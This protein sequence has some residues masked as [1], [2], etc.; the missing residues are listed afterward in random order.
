M[1][2]NFY[3]ILSPI[4]PAYNLYTIASCRYG[5]E[6]I[7][8]SLVIKNRKKNKENFVILPAYTCQVVEN[9]ILAAGCLPLY[10]DINEDDWSISIKGFSEL[11]QNSIKNNNEILAVL[12]QHTYG[13]TPN[14]RS[15]IIELSKIY[16]ISVIDD[17]AHCSHSKDYISNL[18]NY[19]SALIGSFQSSKSI[20]AFQGGLIA[21]RK[22]D[23]KLK[24]ITLSILSKE[25]QAFSLRL[26]LAQLI[27]FSL[28]INNKPFSSA[29]KIRSLISYV[30]KG[31][32]SYEKNFDLIKYKNDFFRRGKAN[33]FTNIFIHFALNNLNKINHKRLELS[34][35]YN[36]IFPIN[37]IIT[38]QISKGNPLLLWPIKD[39][40]HSNIIKLKLQS[41]LISDWYSPM[42]F[43]NSSI[44]KISDF[45]NYPV[46]KRLSIN[47]AS[48]Y[49]NISKEDQSYLIKTL[50]E[51]D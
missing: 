3:K 27:Y 37:S 43:P 30:Y 2:S 23:K 8:R 19:S 49:T 7:L 38:N 18:S 36:S 51:F 9:A 6:L 31:M 22:N 44:L 17:I 42:I 41:R 5:I 16:N 25:K 1:I 48:L 4:Y 50:K 13:I 33:F 32:I 39:K 45:A 11:I 47:C 28:R 21:I 14:D 40:K 12:I 26:L 15:K 10:C 34:I 35:I 29:K 46:A 24:Q 20:S